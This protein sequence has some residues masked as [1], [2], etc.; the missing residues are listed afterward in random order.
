MT[1]VIIITI[2]IIYSLIVGYSKKGYYNFY[3]TPYFLYNDC[4]K[5]SEIVYEAT[6]HRCN[7]DEDLFY[8]SQL[9]IEDLFLKVFKKHNLKNITK[10][11]LYIKN[12][13]NL[14]IKAYQLFYNK[15]P[16]FKINNKIKCLATNSKGPCYPSTTAFKCYYITYKF[17][18]IYPFLKESL[19]NLTNNIN[20]SLIKAGINYPSDI[21]KSENIA[22]NLFK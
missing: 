14:R 3:P 18:K 19:I 4:L 15:L 20:K 2:I 6:M 1:I 17:S 13:D 22:N 12:K 7:N 9:H 5:E 8:S 21:S 11:D 16:P 10:E